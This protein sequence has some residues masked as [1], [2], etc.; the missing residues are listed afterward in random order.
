[1]TKTGRERGN[2][3]TAFNSWMQ[4][5]RR[6]LMHNAIFRFSFDYQKIMKGTFSHDLFTNVNHSITM[7]IFKKAMEEF[8]FNSPGILK[9]ELS[10]QTI[11]SFLLDRF[12]HAVLYYGYE[13]EPY[14]LTKADRKLLNIFSQ[15]Y[16]NDYETSKTG[17]EAYDLY[18]RLLMVTDYISGMTDSYARTLYRELSGIE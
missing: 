9:L 5:T 11:L 14:V 13:E 10:A 2:D 1:M 16:L 12:V 6:W 15:N 3:E 4:Y 17:D 18:L 8:I 7:N